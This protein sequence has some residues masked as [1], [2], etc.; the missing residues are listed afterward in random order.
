MSQVKPL[1]MLPNGDMSQVDTSNDDLTLNSFTGNKLEATNGA[2]GEKLIVQANAGDNETKIFNVKDS[3]GNSVASID[4]DGDMIVND[5]TVN[6]VET[7]V[8]TI[9]AE[10]EL[11]VEG[12]FSASGN[13]TLG[14]DSSDSITFNGVMANNIDMSTNKIVNLAAPTATGDA[15]T[16]KYVDDKAAATLSSANST[17]QGYVDTLEA[18]VMLLDG[19]QAM[20]ADMD[21]GGFNIVSLAEP[22]ASGDAATKNYVDVAIAA[23]DF[24]SVM[25]LDGSQAMTGDMDLDSNKILNLATPTA[26]GD[27]ANKFYV[28]QQDSNVLSGANTYTDSQVSDLSDASMLLDGSQAMTADM[29]LGS[30]KI[31]NLSSPTASGDAANKQYVDD[32]VASVSQVEDVAISFTASGAIAAG[33]PVFVVPSADNTVAEGDASDIGSARLVGIAESAITDSE[34]GAITVVGF[35]TIPTA[36]IDGASFTVGSPVYLSENQ[37]N[38]TS[39]A[40]STPGSR[41][42]QVGIATSSDQLV[43]ELKQGVTIT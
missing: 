31:V 18:N 34:S 17:A 1:K 29:D 12:N 43:I 16:K 37:G 3:A 33:S 9:T 32:A 27:A 8:G 28:D 10:S 2:T 15:T 7:I 41:V 36:Q 40:P 19:S 30:N 14:S 38:L 11:L 20:T 22:S 39:T 6:G 35:A 26:S 13:V 4:E 21:L 5:L 42:Y 24:T 23:V 25:L